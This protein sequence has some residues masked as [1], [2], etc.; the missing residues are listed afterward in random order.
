MSR[1]KAVRVLVAIVAVSVIVWAAALFVPVHHGPLYVVL[2]VSF[3]VVVAADF[4]LVVA[5]VILAGFIGWIGIPGLFE[6][7]GGWYR[8]TKTINFGDKPL[9]HWP[10]PLVVLAVLALVYA[11]VSLEAAGRQSG[12]DRALVRF[13]CQDGAVS[14]AQAKGCETHVTA[15]RVNELANEND[16]TAVDAENQLSNWE[17]A[18]DGQ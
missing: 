5:G 18:E 12:D 8:D 14:Q 3:W 4:L 16:Q 11:A 1:E 17:D 9:F 7:F 2:A 10:G 13:Y 6:A 15:A